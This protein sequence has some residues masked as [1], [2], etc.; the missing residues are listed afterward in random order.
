MLYTQC[1]H[2]VHTVNTLCT[3]HTS[4]YTSIIVLE[5]AVNVHISQSCGGDILPKNM[6]LH[7]ECHRVLGVV[8]KLRF[9]NP[10]HMINKVIAA[11]VRHRHR[12]PLTFP[13]PTAFSFLFINFSSFLLR[14][15]RC[16][17]NQHRSSH[18]TLYAVTTVPCS[19][20]LEPPFHVPLTLSHRSMCH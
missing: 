5:A 6:T 15:A 20:N 4:L 16:Y 2:C 14:L 8:C 10:R 12:T 9:G 17:N 18:T 13:S 11:E 19:T 3:L 1:V 7:T